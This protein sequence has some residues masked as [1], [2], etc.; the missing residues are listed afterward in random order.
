M[1]YCPYCGTENPSEA[2][3]CR[4]CGRKLVSEKGETG[5]IREFIVATTPNVPGYRVTKVFGVVTGITARTRGI[6]GRILAGI[7]TALG[8][9]IEAF[10]SEMEKAR[11]EALQRAVEKASKIGANALIGLDFETSDIFNG[12]VLI[13]ATGTAVTVEP[14]TETTE[15]RS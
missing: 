3:F 11:R 9:E 5:L 4:R 8:G 6:G 15:R 2:K 12:V 7:Q 10:T 1:V 14:S 13:S